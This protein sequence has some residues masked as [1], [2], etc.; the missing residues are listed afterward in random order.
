MPTSGPEHIVSSYNDEL[1]ALAQSIAEMGGQVEVAIENGTKALLRLD[2]ELADLTIIADQ[3]IDDMQR[4]IDDMA[5]SMIARR[6]PMASDL[7]SIITAIH[8]ASDLER[9]GD[10][11]KQLAR[12]SLKL[13]GLNLQPTFYNGV[14]NMTNLVLRQIKDALDSYSSRD[15]AGAIEVC[16]RDDEVDAMYTSLF[17][18]L[19]TYMMEDPRNITPCTHLLFCAKNLER[20]GDHATNIAERAYYLQ[21][22]KQLTSEVVELHRTQLKA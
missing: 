22:G 16:N 17:R 18:E 4:R 10:M 8:V 3:R 20:I 5:V 14:K 11:A 21:T 15:S 19:L 2:R 12:R 1:V 9:V 7:R 13:E 6:Q